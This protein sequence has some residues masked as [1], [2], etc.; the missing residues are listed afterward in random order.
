MKNW[1]TTAIGIGF[2]A[3]NLFASGAF[4]QDGKF[5]WQAFLLSTGMAALGLVAKDHNVTGG[6]TQQPSV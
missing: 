6:T 2:G 5:N 4:T 3:A 1:K